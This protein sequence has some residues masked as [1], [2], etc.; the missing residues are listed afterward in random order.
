M[1]VRY[2]R[3]QIGYLVLTMIAVASL[4][5]GVTMALSDFS[6]TRFFTLIALV[7]CIPLFGTLSVAIV[8]HVLTI[9]FGVGLFRKTLLLDDVVAWRE[10]ENPWAYGW[11]I[12][13]TPHGWLWN[14]SGYD[15]VELQ[16]KNGSK[17]R[18]GT[19]EPQR[20]KNAVDAAVGE[21]AE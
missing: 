6:W 17:F 19:D 7:I 15:A 11:G 3:T 9:R 21:P 20:L 13:L 2:Q 10:V 16:L 14:V 4:V 18:I 5:L 8:D 12:R 1:E